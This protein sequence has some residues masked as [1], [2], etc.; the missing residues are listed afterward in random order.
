[1]ENILDQTNSKS[2]DEDEIDF[3]KMIC[4]KLINSLAMNLYILKSKTNKWFSGK[5]CTYKTSKTSS[6]R[7]C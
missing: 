2:S 6:T 1:M 4:Q 5:M 7:K 3:L